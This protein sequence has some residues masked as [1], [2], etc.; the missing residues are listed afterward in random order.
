MLLE[1]LI[2]PNAFDKKGKKMTYPNVYV[3]KDIGAKTKV[4]AQTIIVK[5]SGT[6]KVY[7]RRT[8][9]QKDV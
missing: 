9:Y 4:S 2:A 6:G 1:E 3:H 8:I 5:S 7:G